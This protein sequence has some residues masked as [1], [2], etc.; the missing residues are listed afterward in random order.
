MP[1]VCGPDSYPL[2][3]D[4]N[5]LKWTSIA[6]ITRMSRT[7]IKWTDSW[8]NWFLIN[9]ILIEIL[10]KKIS[11]EEKSQWIRDSKVCLYLKNNWTLFYDCYSIVILWSNTSRIFNALNQTFVNIQH[12][13]VESLI[14]NHNMCL[15]LPLIKSIRIDWICCV[16]QWKTSRKHIYFSTICFNSWDLFMCS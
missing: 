2:Q 11:A 15:S 6:S 5:G 13:Y 7:T 3:S 14:T 4:P 9:K 16:F 10:V 1:K 12:L 8:K